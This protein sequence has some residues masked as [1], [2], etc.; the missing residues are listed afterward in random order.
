[1]GWSFLVVGPALVAFAIL[2]MLLL[3]RVAGIRPG[4]L[5]RRRLAVLAGLFAVFSISLAALFA[6]GAPGVQFYWIPV[7][8]AAYLWLRNLQK[9]GH[10]LVT[11]TPEERTAIP[12]RREAIAAASKRPTFLLLAG[13][14]IVSFVVVSIGAG[15][16]LR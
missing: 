13:A 10:W 14:L 8:A 11:L 16:I 1:M 3:Y 9:T 15:L 7:A 5:E 12:A 4:V 2:F 6:V